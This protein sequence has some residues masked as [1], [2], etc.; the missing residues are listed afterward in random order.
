MRMILNFKKLRDL[1]EIIVKFEIHSDLSVNGDVLY[2]AT[3][4]LGVIIIQLS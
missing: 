4:G 3:A 1:T 2:S